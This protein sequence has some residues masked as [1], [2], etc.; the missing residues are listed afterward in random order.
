MVKNLYSNLL[1]LTLCAE[2]AEN[3]ILHNSVKLL[4]APKKNIMLRLKTYIFRETVW[5]MKKEQV[6]ATQVGP[7]RKFYI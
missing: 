4:R 3:N 7:K 2:T 5:R 6:C 1:A